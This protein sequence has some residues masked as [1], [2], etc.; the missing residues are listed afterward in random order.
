MRVLVSVLGALCFAGALVFAVLF[1]LGHAPQLLLRLIACVIVMD[2]S[3][4][5][6]FYLFAVAKVPPVEML[7][8]VTS[9]L[10]VAVSLAAIVS[11]VRSGHLPID[12]AAAAFAT[13]VLVLGALTQVYLSR[14]GEEDA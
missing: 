3:A 4:L 9:P 10:T 12:A 6:M 1:A 11:N 2:H 13:L 8:R 5:T 7:L 14:R